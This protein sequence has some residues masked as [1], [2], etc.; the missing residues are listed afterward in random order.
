MLRR[1]GCLLNGQL[2]AAGLRRGHE[3]AVGLVRQVPLGREVRP[4][5]PDEAIEFVVIRLQVLVRD[6]PIVPEPVHALPPEVVGSPAEGDPAPMVGAAAEHP[7]AVPV[8]L[9]SLGNGI[10]F[11]LQLPAADASV[12]LTEVALGRCRAAPRRFVRPLEHR[13]I[14]GGIPLRTGLEDDYPRARLRQHL[15]GHPA[16]RAGADDAHVVAVRTAD[17]LHEGGVSSGRDRASGTWRSLERP[18][19]RTSGGF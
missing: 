7:R 12:E 17:D 11:A 1:L 4:E 14:G 5:D 19:G 9:L 10:G 8:P 6:G 2:V 13:R 18:A 16:A 15:G 3:D